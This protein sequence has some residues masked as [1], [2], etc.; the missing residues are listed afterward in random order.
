MLLLRGG[1][2]QGDA[3]SMMSERAD[4]LRQYAYVGHGHTAGVVREAADQLV[5]WAGW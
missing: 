3:A 1:P 5:E 4:V 2:G